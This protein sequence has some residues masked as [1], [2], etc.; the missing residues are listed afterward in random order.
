MCQSALTLFF[1]ALG[2]TAAS[3]EPN[4][5]DS[6]LASY[7]SKMLL[8]LL[9]LAIFGFFA[10]KYLP[11]KLKVGAQGRLKLVGSLAL[12]RDVV[13][14]VQT[15][16]EIIAIFVSRTNSTVMGRWTLEEWD[17]FEAALSDDT[18]R[19]KVLSDALR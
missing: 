19:E 11:G 7:V 13:Y 16:P 2:I 6:T 3:A 1:L 4:N 18:P 10:V 8:S 12:G 17:D 5:F 14:L 15:G 9:I